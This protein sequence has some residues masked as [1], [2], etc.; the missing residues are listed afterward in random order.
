MNLLDNDR[1][2][3]TVVGAGAALFLSA[4]LFAIVALAT[5]TVDTHHAQLAADMTA[6]AAAW[7]HAQGHDACAQARVVATAHHAELSECTIDG[8]DVELT[9][10]VREQR[11]T[12]R[13]GPLRE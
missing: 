4:M 10:S 2:N 11:A 12:A 3:A 7:L 1:G 6:V 13:A 8:E 5:R 9:T